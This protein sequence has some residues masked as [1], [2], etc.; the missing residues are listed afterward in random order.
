MS[1][2]EYVPIPYFLV[3]TE[4]NILEW[5]Q[6]S[7]HLFKPSANFLDLVDVFSQEKA[8]KFLSLRQKDSRELSVDEPHD[9]QRLSKAEARLFRK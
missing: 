5:S 2:L 1:M 6:Q 4:F 7:G 8:R 9:E 3:D